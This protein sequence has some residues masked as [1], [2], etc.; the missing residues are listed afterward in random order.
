MKRFIKPFFRFLL[1]LGI[2]L[3]ILFFIYNNIN[4]AYLE[5]CALKG[6]PEESCSLIQKLIDDFASADKFWLLVV[7]ATFMLSNIVRAWRWQMLLKPLGYEVTFANSFLVIMLG[8]FANLGLPRMG[9][10]VRAGALSR[11]EGIAFEESMGTIVVD[12]IMDFI[13]LG[14]MI[15]LGFLFNFNA[16]WRFIEAS[17]LMGIMDYWYLL[18][19]MGIVGLIFLWQMYHTCGHQNRR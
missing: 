9:E 7:L 19:I 4:S 8:Y 3:T 6:I 12:R 14:I 16:I 5:E 18:V 2:G 11:N 1:F 13:C 15:V 17:P 10:F